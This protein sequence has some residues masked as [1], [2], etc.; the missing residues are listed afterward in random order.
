M[1]VYVREKGAIVSR[2]VAAH[3]WIDARGEVADKR[4]Q[5]S[6]YVSVGGWGG[7]PGQGHVQ[8]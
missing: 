2:W 8:V 7:V 5:E 4:R 6:V 1:H 3:G